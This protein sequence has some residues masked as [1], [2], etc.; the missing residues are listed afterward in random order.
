MKK[1]GFIALVLAIMVLFGSCGNAGVLNDAEDANYYYES[2][3]PKST[4]ANLLTD[5][6]SETGTDNGQ[7]IEQGR[8]IVYTAYVN[9]ESLKFSESY[10]QI[11]DL[12]SLNLGY[13][14]QSDYNGNNISGSSQSRRC[15][16]VVRI[17]CDKYSEFVKA[18]EDT[19]NVTRFNE[20][21]SDVT[22]EYY[23]Y[24]TRINTLKAYEERLLE[25]LAEASNIETMLK[26]EEKLSD[27]RYEIERYQTYLMNLEDRVDYSTVTINLRE[28]VIY[29]DTEENFGS[30]IVNAFVT[31]WNILC[32]VLGYLIMFIV[33]ALPALVV[34]GVI[35][36]VI[37][38]IV[39][40]VK[41]KKKK[42][43]AVQSAQTETENK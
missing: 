7:S 30:Q 32:T 37:I 33:G 15:T 16:V 38:L 35:V 39:R 36:I 29:S 23:D 19:G 9:L 2:A 14:S 28:V 20:S 3:A 21:T 1:S 11:K 25:L 6:P 8:K 43:A 12:V 5:S 4:S 31:G 18:L 40:A 34:C 24:T 41:K 26:I 27:V 17:P 13:I 42:K 10:E 22:N